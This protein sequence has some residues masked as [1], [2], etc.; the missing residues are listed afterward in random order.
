MALKETDI[1]PV[2][3]HDEY[4]RLSA[5]DAAGIFAIGH[6]HKINCPACG[7]DDQRQGFIKS[8]FNYVECVTCNSLYQSPRPEQATFEK[9]Y[10][11]STS[12]D[13]WATE[14]FPKVAEPRRKL[15]YRP[16][17]EKILEYCQKYGV[18]VNNLIDVGAGYGLFLEEWKKIAPSA[19]LRAV[20]PGK[21]LASLCRAKEFE[22]LESTAE[23]AAAW[24]GTAELVTCFEVFEHSYDPLAFVTSL[25]DLA[26]PEGLVVLTTLGVDGFDIQTLWSKS[27]SVSPPHHI[28]FLSIVGFEILFKRIGF[29]EVEIITPGKLDVDIVL[30][31]AK[32]NPEFELPA[33]FKKMMMRG[34][35]ALR[36][37]QN[38]LS[39]H[40]LSSHTW[41]IAKK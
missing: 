8:D 39:A 24:Q 18:G 16:R 22:V 5:V 31:Y 36:D 19:R 38:Y 3:L 25:Y 29:R 9:F 33:F 32:A 7:S 28:N 17:A 35:P 37:F 30:N 41:I 6:R 26:K 4:I 27:K 11:N 10:S 14:F 12:A 40:K 34:E 1:R 20:E 13:F 23:N 21:K 15:I 2:D